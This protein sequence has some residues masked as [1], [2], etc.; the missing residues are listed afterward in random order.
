M[1]KLTTTPVGSMINFERRGRKKMKMREEEEK[2]SAGKCFT[3][4]AKKNS[5]IRLGFSN[6]GTT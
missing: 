3:T 5:C 4:L 6:I 1:A 2:F